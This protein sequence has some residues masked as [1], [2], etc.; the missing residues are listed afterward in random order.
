METLLEDDNNGNDIEGSDFEDDLSDED[1]EENEYKET[2]KREAD[3]LKKKRM[4]SN[5]PSTIVQVSTGPLEIHLQSMKRQLKEHAALIE[6]PPFLDDLMEEVNKIAGL[7]RKIEHCQTDINNVRE[8]LIDNNGSSS[9]RNNSESSDMSLS[10]KLTHLFKDLEHVRGVIRRIDV[11]NAVGAN[12][13]VK[14]RKLAKGLK[15]LKAFSEKM[16]SNN[17][18]VIQDELKGEIRSVNTRIQQLDDGHIEQFNEVIDRIKK[19]EDNIHEGQKEETERLSKKVEFMEENL[20]SDF[21]SFKEKVDVELESAKKTALQ[22]YVSVSKESL[23]SG[24]Q[25]VEKCIRK[26]LHCRLRARF[27]RWQNF[28]PYGDLR[29]GRNLIAL[30]GKA[31][32]KMFIR[33]ALFE[34]KNYHEKQKA[35]EVI[36]RIRHIFEFKISCI[37]VSLYAENVCIFG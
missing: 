35:R 2:L 19:A 31:H 33:S 30:V 14:V 3:K 21:Y 24:V 11:H 5:R 4:M 36:V 6:H 16:Y 29:R 20:T 8:T 17:M 7:I 28:D 13:I 25:L 37:A 18:R 22:A 26:R 34:W 23:G 10:E 9:Q 32:K 27:R 15:E 12:L 1:S